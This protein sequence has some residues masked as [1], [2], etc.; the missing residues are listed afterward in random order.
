VNQTW[1]FRGSESRNKVSVGEPAE[2]SLTL[3]LMSVPQNTF[4]N[5]PVMK[6][7]KNILEERDGKKKKKKKRKCEEPLL[8]TKK[9][10]LSL[11]LF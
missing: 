6:N 9:L 11:V 1:S 3:K 10:R 4:E 7:K 8:R 2:G 5:G